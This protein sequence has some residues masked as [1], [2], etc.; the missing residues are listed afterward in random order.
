MIGKKFG[1]LFV[2]QDSGKRTNDRGIIWECKCDC[3][4]IKY[5][6]GKLLKNEKKPR[7]CGCSRK[8]YSDMI[9][10]SNFEKSGGCWEWKGVLNR[11]GYGKIGANSTAHRRSYEKY[12]GKIPKGLFVCHTCDNRKCVNPEHLFLGTAKDNMSDMTQKARRA[13]GS[14]TGTSI[15]NEQ[16]VLEIRKMRISGKEY[17]EICKKYS[18]CWGTIAKI[19][20]NKIWKHVGLGQECR[21]VKQIRRNAKG[22]ECGNAKLNEEQVREIKNLLKEGKKSKD[23]AVLFN[24]NKWTISHIKQERSWKHIL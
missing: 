19:C 11:G 21:E 6:S 16:M 1:M 14:K 13:R 22:S 3:G 10:E 20:K 24:V 4:N 2:I 17:D 23:I 7:S 12:K 5:V 9:F 15:L 8:I 18:V